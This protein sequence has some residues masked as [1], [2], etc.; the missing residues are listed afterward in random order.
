M[1]DLT[2]FLLAR[3]AEGEAVALGVNRWVYE[4]LN[5]AGDEHTTGPYLEHFDP[6]RALAECEAKRAIV[7]LH[8]LGEPWDEP[9]DEM[10]GSCAACDY[11]S[12]SWP[13]PT[14]R[15]LALPYADHPDYREEWRA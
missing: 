7:A 2:E 12:A 1:S 13:C 5:E 3:V 4:H 10:L 9:V 6:A 11:Q 8:V 14:L 15:I